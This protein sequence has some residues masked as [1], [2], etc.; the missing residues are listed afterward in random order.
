MS[1]AAGPLLP[2]CWL[3]HGTGSPCSRFGGAR[4]VIQAPRAAGGAV[5]S[6]GIASAEFPAFCVTTSQQGGSRGSDQNG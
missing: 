1:L 4:H 2:R 6:R 5:K 3:A